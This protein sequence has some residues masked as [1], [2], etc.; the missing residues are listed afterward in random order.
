M[1]IIQPFYN[2]P[3]VI[4]FKFTIQSPIEPESIRLFGHYKPASE[5]GENKN[6]HLNNE[7]NL[8]NKIHTEING[9]LIEECN[10]Y[11]KINSDMLLYNVCDSYRKLKDL[12]PTRIISDSWQKFNI[13][14]NIALNKMPKNNKTFEIVLT[15]Y[16]SAE[17]SLNK[18]YLVYVI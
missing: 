17:Y 7:S 2:E 11:H 5:N 14:L 15:I 18:V 12:F 6:V 3:T 4:K 16:T 13:P 10:D 9:L 1:E 8:I